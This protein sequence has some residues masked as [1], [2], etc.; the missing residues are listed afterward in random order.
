LLG[1][2]SLPWDVFTEALPSNGKSDTHT[3]TGTHR[4]QGD[5]VSLLLFLQNMESKLKK[6]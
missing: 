5:F 4:E 2:Y 1:V 3:D 6:L